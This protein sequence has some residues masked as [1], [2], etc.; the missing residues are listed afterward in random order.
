MVIVRS[1][2]QFVICNLHIPCV[3]CMLPSRTNFYENIVR[4]SIFM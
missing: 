3:E 4:E 2:L 1:K